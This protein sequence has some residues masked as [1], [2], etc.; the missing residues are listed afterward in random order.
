MW[1]QNIA[2][3]IDLLQHLRHFKDGYRALEA[4]RGFVLSLSVS[5]LQ[6][7]S[8]HAY[9]CNMCIWLLS[10]Y[11]AGLKISVT[12]S[13]IKLYWVIPC[14]IYVLYATCSICHVIHK[15]KT[16]NPHCKKG[17]SLSQEKKGGILKYRLRWSIFYHTQDSSCLFFLFSSHSYYFQSLLK[18][19]RRNVF[20]FV[21]WNSVSI[22]SKGKMTGT[23][24]FQKA[25]SDSEQCVFIFYKLYLNFTLVH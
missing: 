10:A 15:K 17:E 8:F 1:L 18:S 16:P 9:A 23:T 13:I 21:L 22:L 2:G 12:V 7:A 11:W 24:I 6:N 5:P 20:F 14:A 19:G 4:Q 25:L 3:I